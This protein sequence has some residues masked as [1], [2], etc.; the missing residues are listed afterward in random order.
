MHQN[1]EA[2]AMSSVP[3]LARARTRCPGQHLGRRRLCDRG[4]CHF[5]SAA[6]AI[7]STGGSNELPGP[8]IPRRRDHHRYRQGRVP[9]AADPL[10]SALFAGSFRSASC[11]SSSRAARLT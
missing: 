11:S 8:R 6:I 3:S 9:A 5:T 1:I 2:H 7:V 10:Q 4:W